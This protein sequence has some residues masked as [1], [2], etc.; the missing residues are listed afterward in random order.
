VFFGDENEVNDIRDGVLGGF[1]WSALAGDFFGGV[2]PV[3]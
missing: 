3:P 2:D 1:G